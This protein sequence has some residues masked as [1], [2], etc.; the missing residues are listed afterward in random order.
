MLYVKSFLAGVAA[1]IIYMLL[2]ATLGAKLL[3]P[4]PP[5]LPDGGGY[6]SNSPWIPLWAILLGALLVAVAA[7]FW[8]YRQISK[9]G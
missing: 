8:T 7:S 6:I 9:T 3:L 2:F 5:S 4:T 1:L